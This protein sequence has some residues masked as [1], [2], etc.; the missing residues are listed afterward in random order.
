M[1]DFIKP[2]NYGSKIF[3]VF[4]QIIPSSIDIVERDRKNHTLSLRNSI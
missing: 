1:K 3:G 2:F 4:Y